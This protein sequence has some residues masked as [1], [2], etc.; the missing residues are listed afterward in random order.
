MGDLEGSIS[1][2]SG[3]TVYVTDTLSNAS[4][5]TTIRSNNR[6]VQQLR[7]GLVS[8]KSI[9]IT[10]EG[11]IGSADAPLLTN[12]SDR[13]PHD[14]ISN[15]GE[16]GTLTTVAPTQ[17]VLVASDHTAGGT[18]G[19]VYRYAGSRTDINLRNEDFSDTAR[20]AVPQFQPSLGLQ[21]KSSDITVREIQGDLPV[22]VVAN[23]P[24]GVPATGGDVSLTAQGSIVQ[25]DG[26]GFSFVVGTS[27]NLV[28]ESGSIGSADKP[29]PVSPDFLNVIKNPENR[30]NASAAGDI[31]LE[32]EETTS[33]DTI[34][35]GGDVRIEFPDGVPG[36]L[37]D[38]N[39]FA[40]RDERAIEEVTQAVWG[41]L[42][43]TV[44]L[45]AN[46]K[47]AERIN[48]II[49]SRNQAYDAYWNFRSQQPD[50]SVYDSNFRVT[51]TDD[52][53]GFYESELRQ[54]GT[55]QGLAGGDLD[56]FVAAGIAT[57]QD[58]RTAQYHDLHDDWGSLGDTFDPEFSYTP[59][60]DEIAE[61]N[62]STKIWTVEELLNL[63][64]A[65]FLNVTDTE[66][67]IEQ[68]NII[69]RNIYLNVAG[70][71]GQYQNGKTVPLKNAD[72]SD[73]FLTIDE[74]AAIAAAERG[75]VIFLT[76]PPTQVVARISPNNTIQLEGSGSD[77]FA[78]GFSVGQ[79]IYLESNTRD[80]TDEGVFYEIIS[81]DA[82]DMVLS[83]PT[84][85]QQD[86][87]RPILIAPAIADPANR[88]SATHL[89][90]LRRE[91]IDINAT[92]F[93]QADSSRHIFLGSEGDMTIDG[94]YAG[95]EQRVQ[96]KVSGSLNTTDAEII[97]VAGGRIVLE[98][99]RG[100]I[101]RDEDRLFID[102]SEQ[103][104]LTARAEQEIA[105]A[106]ENLDFLFPMNLR[107]NQ[108][109]S[110]ESFVKLSSRDSILDAFGTDETNIRGN[111]ISLVAADQIGNETDPLDIDLI[112]DG[113]LDAI[114]NSSIQISETAGNLNLR[115]IVSFD[116]HVTLTADGSIL[117]AVDVEE[118]YDNLENLVDAAPIAGNPG[119]DI[120]G[121]NITLVSK[122]GS[123][124][125]PGNELD[126]KT[127]PPDT[128]GNRIF[129]LTTSSALGTY[130]IESIDPRLDENGLPA[131]T[132][133]LYLGTIN[134]NGNA[135]FITAPGGKIFNGLAT[136]EINVFANEIDFGT[137]WK[138]LA[139]QWVG[140]QFTHRISDG[141]TELRIQNEIPYRNPINRFDVNFS[142]D[143]TPIDALVIINRLNN[144]S[145]TDLTA[146]VTPA[147]LEG[148]RYLDP[149]N[150]KKVNPLDALMIINALN[151]QGS[152]RQ[153][154]GEATSLAA[155]GVASPATV[156]LRPEPSTNGSDHQIR[157]TWAYDHSQIKDAES[158]LTDDQ[159]LEELTGREE[160]PL[161]LF[162][163][164]DVARRSEH[165]LRHVPPNLRLPSARRDSSIASNSLLAAASEHQQ[166]AWQQLCWKNNLGTGIIICH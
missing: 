97:D 70:G 108:V 53:Q 21:T 26:V 125:V 118:P 76:Q 13:L 81:L 80:T 109:F 120:D 25:I 82:I 163:P 32:L 106:E 104:Y 161:I 166:L 148:F 35:A 113:K 5:S 137:D 92:G 126:I 74:R 130:I 17:F 33:I 160:I 36:T 111:D 29:F 112:G 3:G 28:A 63:Q 150:D 134:T 9:Q 158:W 114:A 38:G 66:F 56:A 96:I 48:A 47:I 159:F 105:I 6:G 115:H 133:D 75:D 72:G 91:D 110:K 61:I 57:L 20:W 30:L 10:T 123:I 103:G 69:G 51:L 140:G 99:A 165:T 138:L 49:A 128:I 14:F 100:N 50:P 93:V 121:A 144:A 98:A 77:W 7:D 157:Q 116:A 37:I 52:E 149:N 71:I 122:N 18:P 87:P 83:T 136:G 39:T 119:M 88:D 90:V 55:D 124:G 27:V 59:T 24:L 64:S 16:A 73:A 67:V 155:V 4:G 142:G 95:P 2:T 164:R 107:V 101:G 127:S 23:S 85:M 86:D 41:D 46:E 129:T 117:D 145:S 143:M 153:G 68:P 162:S 89:R 22:A 102:S 15:R 11:P 135:A 78:L 84:R 58:N 152:G 31:S 62:A 94:I 146:P 147:D 131:P 156:S 79:S 19:L 1:I 141:E 65:A 43:L 154:S 151:R 44:E 139:P 54:Q 132:N 60:G 34:T 8:G 42:Q 12:I 45:G 40:V